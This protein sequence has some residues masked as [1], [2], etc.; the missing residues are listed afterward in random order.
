MNRGRQFILALACFVTLIGANAAKAETSSFSGSWF[1]T[2]SGQPFTIIITNVGDQP[3]ATIAFSAIG[4]AENLAVLGN[5]AGLE[6]FWRPLDR[7]AICLFS[8][9]GILWF[10]YLEGNSVRTVALSR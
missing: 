2:L 8:Q 1:G 6:Y 10:N 7:A 5:K 4:K 3:N 9:N